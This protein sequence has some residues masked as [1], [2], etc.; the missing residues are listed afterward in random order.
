MSLICPHCNSRMNIRSSR[1][2]TPLVTESWHACRND[3]CAFKVKTI[4]EMVGYA[5]PSA[6]PNPA[7]VL[8]KMSSGQKKT[9]VM[10][11]AVTA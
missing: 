7:I 10:P 5:T 4:T 9:A 8:P 1:R 2:I 11:D 6:V 3:E